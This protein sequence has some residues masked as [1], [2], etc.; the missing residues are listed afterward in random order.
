[1]REKKKVLDTAD[2]FNSNEDANASHTEW[3]YSTEPSWSTITECSV[4]SVK[5]TCDG[6]VLLVQL[7]N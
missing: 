2:S 5:S 7:A 6:R 4:Q 3:P 1:M